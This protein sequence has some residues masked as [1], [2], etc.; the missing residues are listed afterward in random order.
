M[1]QPVASSG[2]F[3]WLGKDTKATT[4]DDAKK[5]CHDAGFLF[6]RPKTKAEFGTIQTMLTNA[7]C[8]SVPDCGGDGGGT[9]F[10]W[11]ALKKNNATGA[12][13]YV[14]GTTLEADVY[15]PFKSSQAIDAGDCVRLM[16]DNTASG[17]DDDKWRLYIPKCNS[18]QAASVVCQDLPTD[19]VT[20][21]CG[22]LPEDC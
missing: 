17:N 4:F 19:F 13:G 18:T 12:Y 21:V 7:G 14:G 8:T 22:K 3:H 16:R 2:G 10:P 11:I 15:P 6:A 20:T 5:L 1:D 9:G